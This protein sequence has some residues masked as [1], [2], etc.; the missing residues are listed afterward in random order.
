MMPQSRYT[1][2][3][4][5]SSVRTDQWATF[6]TETTIRPSGPVRPS[7]ASYA[8][9]DA[10][11]DDWSTVFGTRPTL[12]AC[13]MRRATVG[14][15]YDERLAALARGRVHAKEPGITA[16]LFLLSRPR[17]LMERC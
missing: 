2:S 6:G 17:P 10:T 16:G 13:P 1:K 7:T 4:L 9:V 15:T 5:A 14:S 8:N 11:P 12:T 3:P